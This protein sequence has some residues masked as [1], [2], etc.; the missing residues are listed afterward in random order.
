MEEK[1][2]TG[3]NRF[4]AMIFDM[5][6]TVIDSNEKD[7]DAWKKVFNEYGVDFEYEEY[8]KL[9]GA[10]STEIIEKYIDLN[11]EET[12]EFLKKKEK[13]FNNLVDKK[14]MDAMPH[15]EQVLKIIKASNLKIGLATGAQR[16][17]LDFV[18]EEVKLK[19]YFDVLV[20]ADDVKKGKPDPEI[21]LKALEKLGVSVEE[22]VIWEDAELGVQA[23]K[24]ANLKCIAITT[25]NGSNRGLELA[26][27]T[28][29][30]YEN[31]DVHKLLNQL[32]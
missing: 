15:I 30:S 32:K 17:K 23:A 4:K 26:D 29:D 19:H 10:K 16:N 22:A 20:T 14:G 24:N 27:V 5:D 28:I 18:L 3:N 31:L 1:E 6:G 7:F 25:T 13:A 11:E 2:K 21:F 8:K 12:E 9:L